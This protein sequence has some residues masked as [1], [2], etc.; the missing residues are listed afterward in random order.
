MDTASSRVLSAPVVWTRLE[1]ATLHTRCFSDPRKINLPTQLWNLET[2]NMWL[3]K[4]KHTSNIIREVWCMAVYWW[5]SSFRIS[6]TFL[7]SKEYSLAIT[8]E[9]YTPQNCALSFPNIVNVAFL[10][11]IFLM[12]S[13]HFLEIFIKHL[14]KHLP[15]V[16]MF[17]YQVFNI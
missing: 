5:I 12:F 6:S 17:G 10:A 13:K 11:N 8:R 16:F 4:I 14:R 2:F 7:S 15:N 9:W 3:T 1:T